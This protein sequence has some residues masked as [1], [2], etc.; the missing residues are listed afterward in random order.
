MV[1]IAAEARARAPGRGPE[2]GGRRPAP[3]PVGAGRGQPDRAPDAEPFAP[4]YDQLRARFQR[5]HRPADRGAGAADRRH[6]ATSTPAPLEI[7]Q[8]ADDLSR[9]TEN[10]A[11]TLEETA[12]ALD[13]LTASV[14]LGHRRRR[15]RP[16]S[17]VRS[18]RE[19]AEDS[20][21]VVLQ[22]VEAMSEIEK[23]S[24][25]ISQIIGVIDD[26]AFQTNLLAL[27]AGV[28]A[29]RA[30]EAGRGFA[31]V[32]SEV[33]SLA[34]RSSE[35]AKE[36]KTLISASSNQ[37]DRGVAL[38]G[39]DRRGADARSS[40]ASPTS[41]RWSPNI[42]GSSTRAVDRADRDQHRG[43]PAGPG[44][45]AERRDGRAVDR[46]QPFAEARGRYADPAGVAVPRSATTAGRG[47]E[48]VGPVAARDNGR[49]AAPAPGTR[50]PPGVS[51]G[52]GHRHRR[53]LGRFLNPA[54]GLLRPPFL[55]REEVTVP[56]TRIVL[57]ESRPV[58]RQ[59]L[60]RAI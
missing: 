36:I 37:V 20:G 32:A 30:G 34:Q 12:A 26:I 27:N 43:Q 39:A 6:R 57:A 46:R 59:R 54:T 17:A 52:R 35:A 49:R 53:W 10:Q 14:Q 51:A 24:E 5:R 2:A 9:R 31:V 13:E 19:N 22:A 4:E 47:A 3:R 1:R 48:V 50:P 38:V 58:R 29:A 11:A 55:T 42:A 56:A 44:H 15:T 23:S 40:T 18:A 21:K 8:A 7:S 45:P 33:R 25:Q 60:D 16:T 41:R 28:E